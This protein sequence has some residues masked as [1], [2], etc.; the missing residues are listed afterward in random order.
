MNTKKGLATFWL[1]VMVTILKVFSIIFLCS[2]NVSLHKM[3]MRRYTKVGENHTIA[4][5]AEQRN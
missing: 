4:F 3:L 5:Q 2:L 1:I